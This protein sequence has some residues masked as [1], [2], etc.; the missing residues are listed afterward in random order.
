MF[1]GVYVDDEKEQAI[2]EAIRKI[3]SAIEI[4]DSNNCLEFTWEREYLEDAI[5]Y[6]LGNINQEEMNS[7]LNYITNAFLESDFTVMNEEIEVFIDDTIRDYK[8]LMNHK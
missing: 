6:K 3:D 1:I 2:K 8:D 5:R 7:V 4:L